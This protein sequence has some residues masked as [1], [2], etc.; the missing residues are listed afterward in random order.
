MS[1]LTSLEN[2]KAAAAQDAVKL[3]HLVT[4]TILPIL[5]KAN[6]SQDTIEKI[7]GL[8]DPAAVKYEQVAFALL[9]QAIAAVQA[10][11]SVVGAGGVNISLDSALVADIKAII[12]AL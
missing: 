1:L 11:E 2:I 4:S 10:A 12:T 9:G 3:E 6:S 8:V 5:I 7:T